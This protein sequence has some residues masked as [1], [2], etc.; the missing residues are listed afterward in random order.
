MWVLII[1]VLVK[2]ESKFMKLFVYACYM[3]YMCLL[4]DSVGMLIR[5]DLLL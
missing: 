1:L 4:E 3:Y 5:S 2:T